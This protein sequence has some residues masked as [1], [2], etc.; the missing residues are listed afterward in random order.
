MKKTIVPIKNKKEIAF[1]KMIEECIKNSDA[2]RHDPNEHSAWRK[3]YSQMLKTGERSVASLSNK[4]AGV[5]SS[6]RI[7]DS[8]WQN[9]Y[10][11][12]EILSAREEAAQK[13]VDVKRQRISPAY[14]K[15]AYQY[16][17]DLKDLPTL[18]RKV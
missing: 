16:I 11:D 6:K 5:C 7:D 4:I 2:R 9:T 18:G 10:K 14:S 17:T 13:E 12:D 1:E 15:G 8:K 3:Q